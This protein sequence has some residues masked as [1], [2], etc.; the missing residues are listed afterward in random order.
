MLKIG[1]KGIKWLS[2]AKNMVIGRFGHY[3]CLLQQKME[4]Y[5]LLN[6]INKEKKTI[7]LIICYN[8]SW[9]YFTYFFY[10]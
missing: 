4:N 5:Q 10:D 8:N 7:P 3:C 9:Y 1:K 6:K 2:L